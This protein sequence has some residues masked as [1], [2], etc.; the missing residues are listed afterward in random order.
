[1][2]R[3]NA[4]PRNSRRKK[5]LIAMMQGLIDAMV[6]RRTTNRVAEE[7]FAQS[8]IN[9]F[10]NRKRNIQ[11]EKF[12]VKEIISTTTEISHARITRSGNFKSSAAEENIRQSNIGNRGLRR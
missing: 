8:M 11:K 12:L 7:S 5:I 9:Y 10:S 1:M 4:A 3:E 6:K 2:T